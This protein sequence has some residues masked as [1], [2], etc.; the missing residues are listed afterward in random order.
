MLLAAGPAAAENGL[1]VGA[2]VGQT[3]LELDGLDLGFNGF[4][5]S[6]S[7]T[8]Y[9]VMVGYRFMGFFAVEAS[10]LDFGNLSDSFDD[11]LGDTISVEADLQGFDAVAIGMIPFAIADVFAKAGVVVWDADLR[12]ALG[13]ISQ[14]DSDSGSDLVVGLGAQVRFGGLAVRGELEYFDIDKADSVYLV[15]VGATFTF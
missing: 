10:W 13:T 1:Y 3:R 4:D 14:L 15:S 9:K 5:F 6:D 11:G 8:S 12:T 7:D 2:S